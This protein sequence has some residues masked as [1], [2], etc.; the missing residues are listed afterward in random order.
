MSAM[1][2]LC[3]LSA[4]EW[5]LV[6]EGLPAT[7]KALQEQWDSRWGRYF[8]GLV[9]PSPEGVVR[10]VLL[11]G[12]ELGLGVLRSLLALQASGGPVRVVGVAT[13]DLID[14]KARIF[15]R[16]RIWRHYTDEA[17]RTLQAEVEVTAQ[18]MGIPVFTGDV[19]S[20][21]FQTILGDWAPDC[22]ISY[23]FGQL[24]PPR[25]FQRPRFGSYNF[26]PSDL[27]AGEGRGTM[28]IEEAIEA[29]KRALPTACHHID[30]AFDTG[31]VVGQGRDTPLLDATCTAASVRD[32]LTRL[33]PEGGRMVRLLVQAIARRRAV[34]HALDFS[35]EAPA[36][37][38]ASPL[39][40]PPPARTSPAAALHVQ[41]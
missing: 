9:R 28:P 25:V 23:V 24:I 39:G 2:D 37:R 18:N 38:A 7:P 13:D 14:R 15:R 3:P 16:R 34:V 20:E 8:P 6:R 40:A 41:P 4:S 19:K 27:A 11:V 32:V 26:H 29:G 12:S 22:L 35:E 17:C 5:L 31:P 1:P 30:E 36:L 21:V 10:V 33:A